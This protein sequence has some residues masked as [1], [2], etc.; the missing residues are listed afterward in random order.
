MAPG[1]YLYGIYNTT[2]YLKMVGDMKYTECVSLDDFLDKMLKEKVFKD[3]IIDLSDA[4]WLDSTNLGLLAKISRYTLSNY[5]KKP[6]LYSTDEDINQLLDNMG[7][8]N[9]F[10]IINKLEKKNLDYNE[11]ESL[12]ACRQGMKKIIL[13]AHE[14]LIELSDENKKRFKNIVNVLRSGLQ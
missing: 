9:F 2:C 6:I 10:N 3:V 8:N 12:K 13:E 11:L 14:N 1:K 7:F 4:S 5:D